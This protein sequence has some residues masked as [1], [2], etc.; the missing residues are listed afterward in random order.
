MGEN[1]RRAARANPRVPAGGIARRNGRPR[2]PPIA[3]PK[4]GPIALPGPPPG[5]AAAA[6]QDQQAV[7][8]LVG[9]LERLVQ[10]GGFRMGQPGRGG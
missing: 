3:A 9:E 10:Q 4:L 5:R 1:A 6:Q 7:E 2:T 8:A